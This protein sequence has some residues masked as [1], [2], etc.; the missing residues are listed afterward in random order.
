MSQFTASLETQGLQLLAAFSAYPH[1]KPPLR[2]AYASGALPPHI[3]DFTLWTNVNILIPDAHAGHTQGLA[4]VAVP[5]SRLFLWLIK[6]WFFRINICWWKIA[7]FASA[8]TLTCL[9]C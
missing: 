1:D 6:V 9:F 5:V 8:K 3:R 4:K 2:L 7:T